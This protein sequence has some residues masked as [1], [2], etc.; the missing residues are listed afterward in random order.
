MTRDEFIQAIAGE[1]ARWCEA[2]IEEFSEQASAALEYFE[3]N[4]GVFGDTAFTWET[5]DAKDIAWE[6]MSYWEE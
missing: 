4:E 2:N 6:E 5:D 1:M 3:E